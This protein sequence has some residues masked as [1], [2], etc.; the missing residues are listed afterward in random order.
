[1]QCVS[2]SGRNHAK[3]SM[4]GMIGKSSR[5]ANLGQMDED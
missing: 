4:I 1:M 3:F 2:V 5:L